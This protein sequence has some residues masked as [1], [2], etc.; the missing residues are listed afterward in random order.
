MTR[1]KAQQVSDLL[2]KI[3]RY[4]ALI[5]EIKELPGVLEL[6]DVFGDNEI[7]N[8]LVE[9]VQARVAWFLAELEEL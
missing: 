5:D 4:E 6:E 8:Q 3:E 7:C 2:F 9:M 1:E